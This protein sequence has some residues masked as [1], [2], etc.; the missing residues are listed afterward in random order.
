MKRK[1]WLYLLLLMLISTVILVT[2]AEKGISFINDI[3]Q[4]FS[5]FVNVIFNILFKK[6]NLM[7]Q[8]FDLQLI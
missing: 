7:Y 6:S 5:S 2:E 8:I 3:N 4:A 1:T